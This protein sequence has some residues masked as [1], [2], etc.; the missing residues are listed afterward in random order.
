M[1][2]VAASGSEFPFTLTRVLGTSSTRVLLGGEVPALAEDGVPHSFVVEFDPTFKR[3]WFLDSELVSLLP[4]VSGGGGL[5]FV[6]AD[7]A[8]YSTK[9]GELREVRIGDEL[10]G[11]NS[12]KMLLSAVQV[13]QTVIAV[14][15]S[16]MTFRQESPGYWI[17][18][19]EDIE[20]E[21]PGDY[22]FGFTSVASGAPEEFCCVGLHGEVWI[23]KNSTWERC[24]VPTNC[25]LTCVAVDPEGNYVIGGTRGILMKGSADKW[26][27][28]ESGP[29]RHSITGIAT[30]QG[31]VYVADGSR[32]M[33]VED[34]SVEEVEI[35]PGA[36]TPVRYL[37]STRD[38]MWA[39][40]FDQVVVLREGNWTKLEL[41]SPRNGLLAD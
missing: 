26:Q 41:G 1:A 39:A 11:P 18:L 32:L 36:T 13:D 19:S 3:R 34:D 38:A 20:C 17:R 29:G 5:L 7:G 30:F 10:S 2:E 25:D 40:S 24:D 4:D 6:C 27:I 28:L 9:D 31:S 14:G 12:A 16:R 35:T 22:H 15:A 8:S 33:K 37:S 23:R 21:Q